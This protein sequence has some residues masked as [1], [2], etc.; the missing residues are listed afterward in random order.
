MLG[1]V[2]ITRAKDV[3][4]HGDHDQS[5]HGAWATGTVSDLK[6]ETIPANKLDGSQQRGNIVSGEKVSAKI[7]VQNESFNILQ[8]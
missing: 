8:I 4:K 3:A 5:S 1:D 6:S 2:E 7:T